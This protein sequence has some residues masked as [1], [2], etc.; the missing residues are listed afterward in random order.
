MSSCSSPSSSCWGKSSVSSLFLFWDGKLVRSIQ[1]L[2]FY[3][4]FPVV[5]TGLSGNSWRFFSWKINKYKALVFLS[6]FSSPFMGKS[7]LWRQFLTRAFYHGEDTHTQ[8]LA[9]NSSDTPKF[10]LWWWCWESVKKWN[11]KK[12]QLMVVP[13]VPRNKS[14][15]SGRIRESN[16]CLAMIYTSLFFTQQHQQQQKFP[17]WIN[18]K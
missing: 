10:F 3:W 1:V 12:V 8:K 14:P 18:G 2:F 16:W 7:V 4:S 17:S 13:P 15:R 6:P 11:G 9:V 5:I